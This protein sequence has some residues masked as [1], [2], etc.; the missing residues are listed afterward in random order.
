MATARKMLS[1]LVNKHHGVTLVGNDAYITVV[2]TQ[3]VCRN[4]L[5]AEILYVISRA[6]VGIIGDGDILHTVIDIGC[7]VLIYEIIGYALL[8]SSDAITEIA[9]ALMRD[10]Q[11]YGKR[12]FPAS[13]YVCLYA[14]LRELS[15]K[16]AERR[17]HI[18]SE[19]TLY[20]AFL[21]EGDN[22]PQAQ[23][24]VLTVPCPA[25]VRHVGGVVESVGAQS[26]EQAQTEHKHNQ[27]EWQGGDERHG[28][29]RL[30]SAGIDERHR[31]DCHQRSPEH[32]LPFGRVRMIGCGDAVHD[33]DARISRCDKEDGNHRYSQHANCLSHGEALEEGEQQDVGIVHEPAQRSAHNIPVYPDGSVA[34]HSHPKKDEQ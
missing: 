12:S 31:D 18:V 6:S 34:E 15:L 30:Q 32:V 28:L 5:F 3:H 2:L 26:L 27:A 21:M 4:L 10:V 33:K 25:S 13:E 29:K 11:L 24:P 14:I 9:Y 7:V 23:L 1:F 19:E 17:L 20:V 16:F 8:L 22:L